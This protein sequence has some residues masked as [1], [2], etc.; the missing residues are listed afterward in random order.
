MSIS[1]GR[2]QRF[3]FTAGGGLIGWTP[4]NTSAVYAITYKQDPQNKP[5]S[6]TVLFFGHSED[7]SREPIQSRH[8]LDLWEN[9]GGSA[10]ELYVF[11]HP[12]PGSTQ[13]NRITVHE[14]LVSEY[15]P[16]CN[17]Y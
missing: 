15:A 6:H 17:R 9:N 1:W 11:I 16:D 2:R 8:V 3:K 4:P 7:L 10:N 12:M 5:K 14:Q 13:W